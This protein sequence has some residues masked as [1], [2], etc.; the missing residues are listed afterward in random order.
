MNA[1]K[2]RSLGIQLQLL[3]ERGGTVPADLVARIGQSLRRFANE[4]GRVER[5]LDE[6][7]A[8]AQGAADDAERRARHSRIIADLK[9][10]LPSA[11]SLSI[12]KRENGA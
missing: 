11:S 1:D 4:A 9:A 2:L 10:G 6:L 5:A 8:E 3:G 12:L 7:V